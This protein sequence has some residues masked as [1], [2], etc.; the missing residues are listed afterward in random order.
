MSIIY[1]ASGKI[2]TIRLSKTIKVSPEFLTKEYWSEAP[3][4]ILFDSTCRQL[5][6]W[7]RP[8]V[9][10]KNMDRDKN[11]ISILRDFVDC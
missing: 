5:Q 11:A 4:S 10:N 2:K 8:I 7:K 9:N 1:Y 6:I 3:L